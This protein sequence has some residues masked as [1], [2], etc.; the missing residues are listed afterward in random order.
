MFGYAMYAS[1]STRSERCCDRVPANLWTVFQ[2]WKQSKQDF[3]EK[4]RLDKTPDNWFRTAF[5]DLNSSNW[6]KTYQRRLNLFPLR[7]IDGT[8]RT[9]TFTLLGLIIKFCLKK[10]S[11]WK[12]QQHIFTINW[13]NINPWPNFLYCSLSLFILCSDLTTF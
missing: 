4:C 5:V 12:L 9:L 10:F 6:Y 2:H 1:P 3:E 8:L 11:L 7:I 13:G